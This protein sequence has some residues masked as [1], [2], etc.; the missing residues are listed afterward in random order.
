MI[1]SN[2]LHKTV[3]GLF[4]LFFIL[5]VRAEGPDKKNFDIAKNLEILNALYKELNMFY[6]DSIDTEATIGRGIRAMLAGLDPY[7]NYIPESEREDFRTMTT[8]EYG[9]IGALIQT[10]EKD[11]YISE[12]YE[13]MPAQ[14]AGLKA[15][16]KIISIDGKSVH[17]LESATVSDMLK[18]VANTTVKVVVERQG[19]KEPIKKDII[20]KKIQINSVPYY[21]VVGENTGYIYLSSFTDKSASEVKNA[22]LDL[23]NNKKIGSLILDLRENPGGI[24]DEA[25]KIVNFFVPK[26]KEVLSTR[27]KVKQWDRTY[28][29]TQEP[30]D[31][32]I[33][34]VVLVSNGSASA[35]E[36]VSGA[37]QDLDR[38]VIV[39]DRTY[40]KGLVQTTRSLP[41]NATLKVTTSK[42]YIPSGRLIQ[43][44]DYSHRNADGSARAI[45]DSLTTAYKTANG[46]IVRD[47]GGIKPDFESK[48]KRKGN[49]CYYLVRD[50]LTFDFATDY[51]RKHKTI[52][53]VEEFTL[54][55]RDFDDFKAFV[56]SKDFKYDRQSE[57]ILKD[58]REMAEFEGYS[59]EAKE[60][61]SALEKKLTHN[62]DH[63]MDTFKKD[64]MDILTVEIVKRYYYQ[65]GEIM[66]SIKDDADIKQAVEILD[67]KDLYEKTLNM[68]GVKESDKK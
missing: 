46:R 16:D 58:L 60:E 56:K 8:G 24:L 19:E 64:I 1:K 26:G 45:P 17:G 20:R 52:P 66:Q 33:P 44:I 14:I 37:L 35:A 57:R 7:T 65:K 10:R 23:K 25:V 9:G 18:G 13:G 38:A 21:G 4:I 12:P 36:I 32:D 5:P 31:T 51:A 68:N 43:A 2:Y 41:Y 48:E 50:M 27:G 49:I 40:G 67:N 22:L 42:Y 55:D 54:T 29:T 63:E 61:F 62:L 6:V 15:G 30:I 3:V 59:D 34:L 11:T 39:G 47:G 28:K 53:P